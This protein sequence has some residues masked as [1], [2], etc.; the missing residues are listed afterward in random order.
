MICRRCHLD[1]ARIEPGQDSFQK[2]VVCA[3]C[4]YTTPLKYY[5][6]SKSKQNERK[7]L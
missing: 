6:K 5:N 3:S 2:D 7:Q 4:G 1:Q